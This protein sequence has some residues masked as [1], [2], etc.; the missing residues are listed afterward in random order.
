MAGQITDDCMQ[1]I[2]SIVKFCARARVYAANVTLSSCSI[3]IGQRRSWL[4]DPNGYSKW[5]RPSLRVSILKELN[6]AVCKGLA[7]ET[8]V[9]VS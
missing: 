9:C 8:S 7:D 4:E 5:A 2:Y 1:Y 6:A 3:L